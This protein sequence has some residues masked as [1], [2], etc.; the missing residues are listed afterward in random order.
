MCICSIPS[1]VYI[2]FRC[3][4]ALVHPV[5]ASIMC[6]AWNTEINVAQTACTKSPSQTIDF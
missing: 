1:A 4:L 2:F 5:L 6:N 3:E